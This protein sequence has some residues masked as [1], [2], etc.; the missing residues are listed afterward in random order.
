MLVGKLFIKA[1]APLWD[2]A[3]LLEMW[4]F[5]GGTDLVNPTGLYLWF[6]LQYIENW[7]RVLASLEAD[8]EH[9]LRRT[10]G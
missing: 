6:Y 2:S 3:S 4:S 10:P 1:V 9:D 8:G 7:V 5:D